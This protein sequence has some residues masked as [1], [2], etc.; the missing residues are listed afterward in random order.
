MRYAY[1][2]AADGLSK[3]L[4][5]LRWAYTDVVPSGTDTYAMSFDAAPDVFSHDEHVYAD[6]LSTVRWSQP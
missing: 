1:L 3:D 6:V 5:H 4:P 2:L